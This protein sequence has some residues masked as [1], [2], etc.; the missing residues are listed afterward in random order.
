MPFSF[1]RC[2]AVRQ[3]LLTAGLARFAGHPRNLKTD[4]YA[5][6]LQRIRIVFTGTATTFYSENPAHRGRIF[7]EAGPGKSDL[8]VALVFESDDCAGN[9]L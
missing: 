2:G 9:D 6:G 1:H 8:D 4:A 5:M 7:D 3:I